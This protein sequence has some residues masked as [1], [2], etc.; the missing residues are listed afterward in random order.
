MEICAIRVS[1]GKNSTS[2]RLKVSLLGSILF[3]TDSKIKKIKA[4]LKICAAVAKLLFEC[5][6][7]IVIHFHRRDNEGYKSESEIA[8]H[9]EG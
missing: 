3:A 4:F 1:Y 8:I 7:I 2:D 6:Y 9:W 5:G